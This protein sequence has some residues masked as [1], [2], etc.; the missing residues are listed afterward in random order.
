MDSLP[1][2]DE[3]LGNIEKLISIL[4]ECSS[5]TDEAIV[6]LVMRFEDWVF[7]HAKTKSEYSRLIADKM[8]DVQNRRRI[9]KPQGIELDMQ[10]GYSNEMPIPQKQYSREGFLGNFEMDSYFDE[11]QRYWKKH[12]S[13]QKFLEPLSIMIAQSDKLLRTNEN[14]ANLQTIQK[15]MVYMY[16]LLQ[17][18]P[19]TKVSVASTEEGLRI[20]EA[21][22]TQIHFW[23]QQPTEPVSSIPHNIQLQSQSQPVLRQSPPFIKIEPITPQ[24]QQHIDLT[25]MSDTPE[26][27]QI[28]AQESLNGFFNG[29]IKEKELD[30]LD[31]ILYGTQEPPD[32]FGDIEDWAPSGEWICD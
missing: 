31:R 10:W 5:N 13:M 6:S 17:E 18:T 28:Y 22:E 8:C 24:V 16:K 7:T 9:A 14:C 15:K 4:R 19:E 21:M 29:L 3:R 2:P 26:N 30:V 32:Y 25:N 23:I 1:Q 12:K 11:E 20:L 27:K